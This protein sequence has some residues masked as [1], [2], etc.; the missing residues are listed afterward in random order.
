MLFDID[1]QTPGGRL[2]CK[3]VIFFANA[4]NGQYSNERSGVSV[5]AARE[6]EERH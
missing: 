5:Q 1:S 2:D 3:T 4:S 6:N